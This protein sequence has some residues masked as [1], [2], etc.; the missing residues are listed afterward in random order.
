MSPSMINANP[1]PLI[2]NPSKN[3]HSREPSSDTWSLTE[4]GGR[5]GLIDQSHPGM[6]PVTI[7]FPAYLTSAR[8]RSELASLPLIRAIGKRAKRVVDATAGMGQDSFALAVFGYS[9]TAFERSDKIAALLMDALNRVQA[10][11][12]LDALL[13]DR[14]RVVHADAIKELRHLQPGPEVVYID[15]MYPPRRKK[16]ALAKKDMQ[17]LRALVGDDRDAASLFDVA[18]R[19][20]SERVVVKRPVY[21]DPIAAEPSMSYESKLVR[22]DVYLN[23]TSKPENI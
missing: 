15:P 6:P 20:A 11:E 16:S 17:V 9:V 4:S 22:F 12:E 10:N 13:G 8:G 23:N 3:S 14:L 2:N 5:L 7:E 1:E 18:R 19:T 21:A